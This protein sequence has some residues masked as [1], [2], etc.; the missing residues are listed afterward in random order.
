MAEGLPETD[1]LYLRD[2][3]LRSCS[4]RVIR[5]SVGRGRRRYLALD[6]TV[7][8]PLSGGQPSDVGVIR[9]EGFELSVRKTLLRRGVVIHFGLLSGR[10]PAEGDEVRC[11]LDWGRRYRV[12]RLHTA[13]HILDAAVSPHY[14][15]VVRT[16]GAMH[17][18]PDPHVDYGAETPPPDLIP[19]IE[20]RAN[21]IV[22]ADLR[23]RVTFVAREETAGAIRWAPNLERLPPSRVYRVVE[24]GGVN[25]VPCTGTHVARTGEVGRI[26]VLGAD[27]VDR[28][29][30]LSYD[31]SRD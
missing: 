15:R 7:F 29:F 23:V 4:A 24:I 17:G 20:E 18:P 21:D 19:S 25:A 3:Y 11:A 8:H 16:L 26:R 5:I 13:G 6:R 14:G 10:E 12:M 30:R 27:P 22:S 1:A 28:G 31:V 2:S 9:G